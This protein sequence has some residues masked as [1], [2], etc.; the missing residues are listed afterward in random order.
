MKK[1]YLLL[2]GGFCFQ[3]MFAQSLPKWANKAKKAVFSVVTY[4]KDNK[5]LNTGNGFYID[6]S[7]TAV[8]DYTLFKGAH[9]A[10]VVTADG[11]ELPVKCIM[12]ANDLYDVVKFKTETDKKTVALQP[13]S[14]AVPQGA[15]V[16]LLPYST[17]KAVNGQSGS[18]EKVDTIG[19]NAYYYTIQ[20]QTGDK[21][22]SCP[23]M[24]AEG[25]VLG[26][27]QKNADA[28]SKVSYAVGISY[29]SSLSI[30][31]L[32]GNDYTLNS[33]GIKKGLPEDESQALVYLYMM[34]SQ[35]NR[36]QYLELLNDFIAQ[37]PRNME[38]YQRRAALYMEYRDDTHNAL[39]AQ[40]LEH[41]LEVASKP[42]E[43]HFNIAKLLYNYQINLNGA[44]AYASWTY[45]RALEEINKALEIAQ[46]GVYYQVQGDIY[47]AMQKY[48]EAYASYEKVNQSSM[49]SAATFYAAAKTK[50]LIKD[51]D[52]NEVIALMDSAVARF[53]EPYGKDA[54]P[55]LYERARMKN[56]LKK[57]REAVIDYN[58]F[59]DAMM[60]Q[61]S[62]EFYLIREQAE[63]QCR[64]YQQAINDINK[65]VELEPKNVDLWIEK[66]GVHLRVNQ[67]EEAMKAL[68]TALSLDPKNAP[69]YRMLG[70]CQV[71]Q[72]NTKEGIANLQKAKELGDTVADELLKKYSK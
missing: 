8:S 11:K 4:N 34:S 53:N 67:A 33:I 72:K 27:I 40:D 25:E 59:Y 57:Y 68:R 37:Y 13:A 46:E 69:A 58:H 23:I 66:G 3:T 12:G 51:V 15:T 5:I 60:G 44:Q 61:V 65:A 26:L 2:I 52:K 55:Y 49:A 20:M 35:L 6:E 64:M 24:N 17:Q 32:S 16:Y 10:V 21:T 54:A 56:E 22:V 19:N 48:A 18:V 47:F 41:M 28:E 9:Y 63:M 45:K 1:I 50:E 38:G 7:G 36:E 29:V 31:A 62:A 30:N 70:Y 39:A 71:Q 43:A 14:Q 42:D